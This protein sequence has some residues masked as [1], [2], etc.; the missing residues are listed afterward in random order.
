M[1][2]PLSPPLR[3]YRSILGLLSVVSALNVPSTEASAADVSLPPDVAAALGRNAAAIDPITIEWETQFEFPKPVPREL[4]N[5]EMPVSRECGQV[6]RFQGGRV[7]AL[8][9]FCRLEPTTGESTFTHVSDLSFDGQAVFAGAG[10]AAVRGRRNSVLMIQTL[11]SYERSHFFVL[12]TYLF[13]AGF[14]FAA[15]YSE[16]GRQPESL[17]LYLLNH[18]GTVREVSHIAEGARSETRLEIAAPHP[19]YPQPEGS[20]TWRFALDETHGMAVRGME[21]WTPDGKLAR[22]TENEEFDKLSNAPG[23]V[24]RSSLVEEHFLPKKTEPPPGLMFPAAVVKAH[25]H[26]K[27]HDEHK[28]DAKD[29]IISYDEA[30]TL[31]SDN[32][33]LEARNRPNGKIVY[34]IPANPADLDKVIAGAKAPPASGSVVSKWTVLAVANV[35]ALMTLCT[36]ILIRRMRRR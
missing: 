4:Q 33:P 9:K 7:H 31:V 36:A 27:E 25:L 13:H 5:K 2:V 20:W 16:L 19:S 14:W 17:V 21:E 32:R 10:K 3:R 29:F 34:E 24:P 6:Y 30:G 35:A 11:D 28:L 12:P 26:V 22:K 1:K 8:V 18:G 15:R 23:W